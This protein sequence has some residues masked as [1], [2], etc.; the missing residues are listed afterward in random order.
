MGVSLR[1]MASLFDELKQIK[2]LAEAE[3]SASETRLRD[4]ARTMFDQFYR[5]A[6]EAGWEDHQVEP[7]RTMEKAFRKE[8]LEAS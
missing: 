7:I 8:M 4:K 1:D 5:E 6:K 2:R 3:R